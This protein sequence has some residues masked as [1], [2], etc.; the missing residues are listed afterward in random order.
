VHPGRPW[1]TEMS[2][3]L[4]PWPCSPAERGRICPK[5]GQVALTSGLN[6]WYSAPEPVVWD[7]FLHSG[8]RHCGE[9]A[10]TRSHRI[11]QAA[12]DLA[13][14]SSAAKTARSTGFEPLLQEFI[15]PGRKFDVCLLFPDEPRTG[16]VAAFVQEQLRGYPFWGGPSTLQKGAHRPDLGDSALPKALPP[17]RPAR[18]AAATHPVVSCLHPWDL[19]PD[20][21]QHLKGEP[22]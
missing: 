2:L 19:N 22:T 11:P 17:R 20:F 1:C 13:E 6:P 9:S 4:F 15:P 7:F 14:L 10:Q 8:R 3:R 18:T 12:G 5:G 21:A 16:P